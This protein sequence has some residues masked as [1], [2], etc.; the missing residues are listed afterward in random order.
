MYGYL[1][2]S[3]RQDHFEVVLVSGGLLMHYQACGTTLTGL[4]LRV[5]WKLGESSGE[6]GGRVY[7]F[8]KSVLVS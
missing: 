6:C 8:A 4:L 3:P 2:L 5:Y 1:P 7:S